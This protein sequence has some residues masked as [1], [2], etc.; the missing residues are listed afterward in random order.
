MQQAF[1]GWSLTKGEDIHPEIAGGHR[2]NQ[3]EDRYHGQ[4]DYR[5]R[6]TTL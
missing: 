4:A 5:I 1:L 6:L 2:G 3:T